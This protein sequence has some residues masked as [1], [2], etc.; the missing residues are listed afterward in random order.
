MGAQALPARAGGLPEEWRAPLV[1]LAAVW[2]GLIALFWPEW[3]AMAHQWWDS[4]TYN[5]ILMVPAIVGWL[6]AQRLP[7]LF[8]LRAAAWGP[9]LAGLGAALVLWVLGAFA[10]FAQVTQIAAVAM[11]MMAVPMVLGPRV[12]AGVLFPLC[13]MAFLVPFGDELVP[14]L[15]T[16]T[17]HIT[18]ALV[19]VS[20]IPAQIDG[21]FIHTPAG[22]FEVA[23]ACSGVKFLVAMTAFGA[24]CAHV[25]FLDW[26]RRAGF[27]ALC[28]VVPV[29]AN[30]VRAWGT[31]YAAQIWG[32]EVAGGIDHIIYGWVFFAI[33]IGLI[34]AAGWR[35]FDRPAGA[36][37]LD[38]GAV[39]GA[40]V[41]DWAEGFVVAPT[42]VLV[43]AGALA[44]AAVGW[45]A[46]ADRLSADMP[47]AITLPDVPGWRREEYTPRIW[48]EPRATGADH[49]LL[50]RYADAQGHVVDVFYGLYAAQGPGKKAGGFG[51]GAL[52]PDSSWSW[53]SPGPDMADAKT[54][55]L[56]AGGPTMRLAATTYRTGDLA[57]GSNLRLKLANITDRL[58]LRRRSTM[59]LI[60]SAV[61]P[62]ARGEGGITRPAAESIAAFRQSTGLIGNW[63]DGIARI[64]HDR[65][66]GD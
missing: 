7:G 66:T 14:L 15:Q 63:M 19:H 21:V 3:R 49:R 37:M 12:A 22:L 46:V 45:V 28:V 17:A 33:V 62:G 11:L 32:R 13:Y 26:R 47:D 51:E 57:T 34:L 24:L 38:L 48:W 43:G 23:E 16:I 29:L 60:V 6:V 40:R 20:A 64:G 58:L 54:D 55:L 61:E 25:C 2:A 27:M 36:P 39:Q 50:G 44:L 53:R 30:G 10:G 9:G 35:F 59:V 4:S 65:A 8:A 42:R 41:L 56:L 31:V 5:H 1:Q 52:T 18:I